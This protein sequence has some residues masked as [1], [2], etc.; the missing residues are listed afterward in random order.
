MILAK[1]I[2]APG[3]LENPEIK[4]AYS[5][6]KWTGDS[7]GFLRPVEEITA[8]KMKIENGFSTHQEETT[9]INGGDFQ[10]NIARL[11]KE[12]QLK[13]DAGLVEEKQQGF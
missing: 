13:K 9:M 3:F 5:S 6:A 7:M 1:K 8:S 10:K 11:K 4:A 2:V 12:N